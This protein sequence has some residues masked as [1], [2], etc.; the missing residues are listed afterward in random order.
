MLNSSRDKDERIYHGGVVG[1]MAAKCARGCVTKGGE[2]EEW[3]Q[4]NAWDGT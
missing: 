3:G 2:L 4:V 1:E